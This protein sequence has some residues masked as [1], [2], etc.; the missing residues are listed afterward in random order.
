M[1][2]QSTINSFDMSH[3]VLWSRLE[4]KGASNYEVGQKDMRKMGRAKRPAG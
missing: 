3:A 2:T 4:G 1:Y